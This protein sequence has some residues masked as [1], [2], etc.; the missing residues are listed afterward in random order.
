MATK[1]IVN[2]PG[3]TPYDVR[4][5]AGALDGLGQRMRAVEALAS[6]ERVLVIT[7]ANV[8]RCV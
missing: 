3:E 2:I 1:V 4:I 7:D 5:G 8:A 6:M